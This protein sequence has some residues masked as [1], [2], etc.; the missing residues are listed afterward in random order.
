MLINVAS[1]RQLLLLGEL[2][3]PDRAFAYLVKLGM[4]DEQARQMIVNAIGFHGIDQLIAQISAD[5][6]GNAML[7]KIARQWMSAG[8]VPPWLKNAIT[9]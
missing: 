3:E 7:A 8:W 4:S 9:S 1:P 6:H 5:P 2:I